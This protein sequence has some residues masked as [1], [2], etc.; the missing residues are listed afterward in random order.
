MKKITKILAV[1][2][3]ALLALAVMGCSNP[4]SGGSGYINPTEVIDGVTNAKTECT[5][6]VTTSDLAGKN[7]SGN[8]SY[9][10]SFTGAGTSGT[11]TEYEKITMKLAKKSD[12]VYSVILPAGSK[13]YS[14]LVDETALMNLPDDQFA[15]A[16]K[17]FEQMIRESSDSDDPVTLDMIDISKDGTIIIGGTVK[18]DTT[19]DDL[20]FTD[21][22]G[23]LKANA[24]F[25]KFYFETVERGSEIKTVFSKIN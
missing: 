14:I 18:E 12:T 10:H 24:D 25:T 2:F 1:G 4:S 3:V 15:Q 22:L 6:E 23:N 19:D 20:D 11:A 8:W 17:D 16:K 21:G 9:V 7:F 13:F 5:F